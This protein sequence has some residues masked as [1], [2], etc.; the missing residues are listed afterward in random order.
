M[1]KAPATLL[2]WF[3]IIA[4]RVLTPFRETPFRE[5]PFPRLPF[6]DYVMPQSDHAEF[7]ELLELVDRV[8]PKQIY[9]H[10][11]FPEFVDHLRARGHN[12]CLARPDD[13]L[14]LFE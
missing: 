14:T 7:D 2:T 4:K 13:Q 12:A 9:T 3:V 1:E 10:H 8:R 5:T 11:G 6:L